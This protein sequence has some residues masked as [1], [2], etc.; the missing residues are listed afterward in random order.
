[1]ILTIP[2]N[3]KELSMFY[4]LTD[5]AGNHFS[6]N[7]VLFNQLMMN[8]DVSESCTMTVVDQDIDGGKLFNRAIAYLGQHGMNEL[9]WKLRD[10][11][12][13]L[14]HGNRRK[15]NPIVCIETGEQFITVRAASKEH[16]VTYTQLLNHVNGVKGFNTVK[17]KTYKRITV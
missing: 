8:L 15:G 1:M 3:H 2:T 14:Q 13:N 4:I 16:D 10:K 12:N 17:G 11:I 6:T 9:Q 5:C 7:I